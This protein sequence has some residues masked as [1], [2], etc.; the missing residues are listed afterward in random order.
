MAIMHN[1]CDKVGFLFGIFHK[2]NHALHSPLESS[3]I[4]FSEQT[5]TNLTL[6]VSMCIFLGK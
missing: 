4:R 2:M 5:K 3:I 6:C 1:L